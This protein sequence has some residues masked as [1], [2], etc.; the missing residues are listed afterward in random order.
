MYIKQILFILSRFLSCLGGMLLS[1]F[2]FPLVS[3]I[4]SKKLAVPRHSLYIEYTWL[5]Y[6]SYPFTSQVKQQN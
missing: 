6:M 3:S 4:S 1:F 5:L 2:Y